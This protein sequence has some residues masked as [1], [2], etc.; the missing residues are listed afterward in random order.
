MKRSFVTKK[1]FILILLLNLVLICAIVFLMSYVQQLLNSDVRINLSQIVTQNKDVITSK[2]AV[3][4]NTM[5]LDAKQLGERFQQ[6][7]ATTTQAQHQAFLEFADYKEDYSLVWTQADGR[8]ISAGGKEFDVS[9]RAYFHV[10]MTGTPN[11]SERIVSL[12]DGAEVFVFCVPVYQGSRII[13]VVQK[14]YT[15]QEMY[16]LCAV[17]LFSEKGSTYII[18]SQGQVLISSDN[19]QESQESDN[20]YQ[21]VR[22]NNPRAARQLE[23]DIQNNQA[24]FMDAVVNGQHIFAAYTP[25]EQL[26]DWHLISS[27]PTD[28]VSPNANIVV[29][30]FY[31]VLL[32]ATLV[33]T[34][35]LL[36]YWSLTRKQQQ[37]LEQL[38]F[39]DQVTGGNSFTKFTVELE[40]ML[41][42]STGEPL[43]ICAIDIDNFKYINGFYSFEAGNMILQTIY[44]RYSARLAPGEM[45]ARMTADKFVMLLRDDAPQRLDQLVELELLIDGIKIYLSAGLYRIPEIPFSINLMV[46][47]AFMAAQRV[48]GLHFKHM[49]R[50]TEEL[51]A[52]VAHNEQLKRAL[53]LALEQGDII[54]FFQP[55]VNINTRKLIGAEALARWRDNTGRLISPGEFIPVCEKTGL[56]SLVDMTIFEQTLQFI[57]RSLQQGVACVPISVNFSRLHLL[58]ENFVELLLQ[59]LEQYQVPPQYIEL[60]LTETVIFENYQTIHTF[61]QEIHRHGLKISMDDFGSGYSSLH[62]LKDMEIDVLKIDRGFLMNTASN[63]RQRIIFGAIVQLAEQLKMEVVVEGVE[64]LE[65][66]QLLEE[67]GCS[68]AQG[69]YYSRPVDGQQFADI[70]REGRL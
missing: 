32:V 7:G 6:T 46:D 31:V 36:Y 12:A 26:H 34:S 23:A 63:N 67:F 59:K 65:N 25:I 10:G 55:K 40:Q 28:A 37:T 61:I 54:P 68:I 27:I 13:G 35:C 50:Y 30:M 3:E 43:Y 19:S 11:I 62:M 17:S 15:P 48:K 4:L 57:Q 18:N 41:G 38:A 42:R 1:S 24:G 60:E 56:I 21:L 8:A 53:E 33:F 9:G 66:V 44:Q 58:N 49:E 2:L 5:E 14:Q 29:K 69:Y 70:Y 22:R 16:D 51:D 20:Y 64:T 45:L 52:E 47:K 39:V